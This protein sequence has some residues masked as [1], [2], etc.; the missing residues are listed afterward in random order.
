MVE[1]MRQIRVGR[2]YR[3]PS[4]IGWILEIAVEIII[5]VELGSGHL[6]ISHPLELVRQLGS[7]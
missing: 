1:L 4:E 3:Q 6:A 5:G 2:N 7:C